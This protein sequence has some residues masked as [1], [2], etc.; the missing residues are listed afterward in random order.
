MPT[1]ISKVVYGNETL[2]DLTSDTVA[3]DKLLAGYTAHGA[4]GA[5][6]SGACAYNANTSGDTVAVGAV[7][8]GTTFHNAA[9]APQVGTMPNIGKQE[10]TLVARDS[11]VAINAGYH[12]GSGS[13]GLGSSDKAALISDNIREGVTILGVQ[14]SYSGESISVEANK[15]VTPSTVAQTVLPTSPTYDYLAQVTVNAIPYSETPNSF[16]IT[17]TI[18]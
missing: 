2:I 7:L 13:I 10:S 11:A 12:D 1:Y 5:P 18:G 17:V 8:S 6:I 15:T 16:G 4:D 14:G 3:A 9:G